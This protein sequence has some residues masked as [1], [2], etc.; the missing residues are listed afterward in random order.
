V[1]SVTKHKADF[2][3]DDL[4]NSF[5]NIAKEF[6]SYEEKIEH[7]KKQSHLH[8][9]QKTH[10]LEDA[11]KLENKLSEIEVNSRFLMFENKAQ[12]VYFLLNFI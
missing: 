10:L 7:L 12:N 5:K 2:S 8:Q 1:P 3:D 4:V 6:E 11:K 9:T